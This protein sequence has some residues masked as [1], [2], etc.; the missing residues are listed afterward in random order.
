MAS[1]LILSSCGLGSTSLGG[2]TIM[3]S[4][5]LDSEPDASRQGTFLLQNGCAWLKDEI[6]ADVWSVVWPSDAYLDGAP[7]FIRVNVGGKSIVDGQRVTL[8][9]G[10]YADDAWVESLVGKIPPACK[11]GLYWLATRVISSP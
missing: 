6:S 11:S 5:H 2:V 4:K 10:E 8:G 9:G 7:G 1:V 3:R